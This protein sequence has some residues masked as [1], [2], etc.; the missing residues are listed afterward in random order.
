M[1]RIAWMICLVGITLFSL[2]LAA[3]PRV[4]GG[5]KVAHGVAYAT[6]SFLSLYALGGTLSRWKR[7]LIVVVVC[8]L[9]GGLMEWIQPLV[10]RNMDLM[11]GVADAAGAIIGTAIAGLVQLVPGF[12]P[13]GPLTERRG[14]SPTG[15]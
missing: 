8:V 13:P 3:S 7:L 6:W 15:H 10:G 11:D 5:D 14:R 9:Y 4:G 12:H 1:I 2:F